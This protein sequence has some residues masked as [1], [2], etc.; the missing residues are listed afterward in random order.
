MIFVCAT[1]LEIKKRKILFLLLDHGKIGA[2]EAP[3]F[4]GFEGVYVFTVLDL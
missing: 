1:S 2:G 4:I 3:E